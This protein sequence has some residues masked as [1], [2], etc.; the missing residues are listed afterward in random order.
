[1]PIQDDRFANVI[2]ARVT[3]SAANVEGFT[4]IQTGVSLAMSLGIVIDEVRYYPTSLALRELKAD[5]DT[6]TMGVYT[7]NNITD[8]QLP[9]DQRIIDF[10]KLTGVAS[11]TPGNSYHV[12][13]PFVSVLSPPLILAAPRLYVGV[14][15]EGAAAA[16]ISD[17]RIHFRYVKLTTVEYL[18]I[19]ETFI[20][21]NA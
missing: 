19:A 14:D 20:Q 12:Q 6:I 9:T 17:F 18:E 13:T 7:S 4:E 21:L 5:T 16:V 10:I 8:L 11:G 1:M 15:S 2:G 3:Q